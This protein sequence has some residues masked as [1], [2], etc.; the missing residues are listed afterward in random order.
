MFRTDGCSLEL[1]KCD[2]T[3]LEVDAIVNAANSALK[4]GGGVAGAIRRA[5]GEEVQRECDE[6]VR[7][8]G[9]VPVGGAAITGAGR[10]RA[11]YVIHAVG[12]VWG[13]GDEERKLRSAFESSIRL[14][15]ERGVRSI[16]FPAISAGIFGV[17]REVS[18]R[19]LLGAALDYVK[20]GTCKIPRIIFCLYDDETYDAFRKELGR[21][22]GQA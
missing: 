3:K 2:I 1:M 4:M 8:N 12:P 17:P 20:G 18:A 14:A 13:E 22:T 7:R 19:A 21:L 11:K 16:A 5:A 6:W 9:P 15:E 10:L